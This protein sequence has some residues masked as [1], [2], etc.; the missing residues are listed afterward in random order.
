MHFAM[1][2]THFDTVHSRFTHYD[3]VYMHFA[4]VHTHFVTVHSMF[5]H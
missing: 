2:Q 4:M 1:V 3:S 5:T